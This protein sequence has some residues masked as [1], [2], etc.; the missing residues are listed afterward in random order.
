MTSYKVHIT[1]KAVKFIEKQPEPQKTRL[2]SAIKRLP[3][4]GDIIKM[5][6]VEETYRLRVG[7]YR[8]IYEKEDDLM[9][10]TVIEADNRGDIY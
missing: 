7:N 8:V 5:Q 4:K 10:I 1:K 9:V 2:Y 6:G 3:E